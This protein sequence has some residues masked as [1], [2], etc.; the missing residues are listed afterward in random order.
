MNF[1]LSP[2][3]GTTLDSAPQTPRPDRRP[4][5]FDEDRTAFWA[6]R[7]S[8]FPAFAPIL[9]NELSPVDYESA[10]GDHCHS[11][12][13]PFGRRRRAPRSCDLGCAN[14]PPPCEG[15][16]SHDVPNDPSEGVDSTAPPFTWPTPPRSLCPSSFIV[17]APHYGCRQLDWENRAVLPR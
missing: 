4:S 13:E 11:P 15:G 6:T 9:V 5:P 10:S 8:V 17:R 12:C 2:R 3:E 1:S 7:N 16:E 14:A